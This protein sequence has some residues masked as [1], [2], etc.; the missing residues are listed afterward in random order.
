M[1]YVIAVSGYPGAGKTSL[2]LGL[3]DVLGDAAPIHMDSYERITTAPMEDIARWLRDGAD[4]DAF[5]FPQL[6]EDLLR[7]KQGLPLEDR[8]SKRTFSDSKYILFETQFGRAHRKTGQHID[9]QIWIDVHRDIA[10]ARNMR[11]LVTGFLGENQPEKLASRMHWLESYLGNYL[12]TV[13]ALLEMQHQRVAG[14][15]EIVVD[16]RSDLRV[17]IESAR[18]EILKRLP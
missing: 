7:L 9:L 12:G 15:A 16:G 14:S 17:M 11:A 1:S 2:V 3:L 10:L 5:E 13:S 4:I 8:L 6:S 18:S